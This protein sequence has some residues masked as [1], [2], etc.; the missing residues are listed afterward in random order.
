MRVRTQDTSDLQFG[1]EVARTFRHQL[2]GLSK[3]LAGLVR[4]VL[5]IAKCLL[6][7]VKETKTVAAIREIDSGFDIHDPCISTR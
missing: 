2:A 7:A 4:T 5:G 1:A 3:W 6:G